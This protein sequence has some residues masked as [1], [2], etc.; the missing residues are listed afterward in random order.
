MLWTKTRWCL[1]LHVIPS[2]TDSNITLVGSTSSSTF[3]MLL[4]LSWVTEVVKFERFPSTVKEVV[5]FERFPSTVTEV[6]KFER[7]PSTF[8]I[9]PCSLPTRGTAGKREGYRA[10]RGFFDP[11]CGK[12]LTNYPSITTRV[13]FVV[14]SISSNI[15]YIMLR[16]REILRSFHYVRRQTDDVA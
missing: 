9:E 3:G 4:T 6:V 15:V 14:F 7:F 16:P 13:R 2:Q 12:G 10:Q 1:L 11:L 5:M 8:R